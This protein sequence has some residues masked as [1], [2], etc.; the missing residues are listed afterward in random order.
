MPKIFKEDYGVRELPDGT[1]IK[2]VPTTQKFTEADGS[3]V[4]LDRVYV[5]GHDG[6]PTGKTY[7]QDRMGQRFVDN[8]P[9]VEDDLSY[10]ESLPC[11]ERR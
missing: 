1:K 2:I 4:R 10:L 6:K 7:L 11:K 3:D 5:L 8:L 9:G